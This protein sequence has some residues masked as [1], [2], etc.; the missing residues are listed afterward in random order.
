MSITITSIVNIITIIKDMAHTRPCTPPRQAPFVP[1]P[2]VF[3]KCTGRGIRRR[4]TVSK[5]RNSLPKESLCPVVP[6]PCLC[7]SYAPTES[8]TGPSALHIS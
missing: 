7:S 6:C 5:R 3:Q 2:R 8:C 4:G 1:A